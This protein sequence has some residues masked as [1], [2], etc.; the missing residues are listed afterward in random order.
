[1]HELNPANS[2]R[3]FDVHAPFWYIK[4]HR[5]QVFSLENTERMLQSGMCSLIES[6]ETLKN[7][8]TH[9]DIC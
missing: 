9:K 2:G 4:I 6:L 1:M 8:Q 3:I 7:K 5:N